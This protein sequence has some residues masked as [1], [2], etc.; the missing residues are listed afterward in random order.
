MVIMCSPTRQ[1]LIMLRVSSG[2]GQRLQV[3]CNYPQH[4]APVF[5]LGQEQHCQGRSPR[6]QQAVCRPSPGEA[7][8]WRAWDPLRHLPLQ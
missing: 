8:S 2:D 4:G 5:L 7:R 6:P 1:P 3:P